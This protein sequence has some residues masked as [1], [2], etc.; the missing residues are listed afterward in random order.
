[1]IAYFH[2]NQYYGVMKVN[3]LYGNIQ[4]SRKCESCQNQN[5]IASINPSS[6]K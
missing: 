5:G 2:T 3:E 6:Q 4:L 1:M